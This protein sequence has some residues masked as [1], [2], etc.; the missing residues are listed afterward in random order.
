VVLNVQS[1]MWGSVLTP[2]LRCITKN[3]NSE[4]NTTMQ[5]VND[6]FVIT[7][8]HYVLIFFKHQYTVT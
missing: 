5:K 3:H 8:F 6:T 2:A 4:T 1:A 7:I